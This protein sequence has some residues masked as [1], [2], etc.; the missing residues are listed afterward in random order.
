MSDNLR[1]LTTEEQ[2][3]RLYLARRRGGMWAACGRVIG[4]D[5]T[6][7]VEHFRIGPEGS[8]GVIVWAAV[9]AE[10]VSP[11]FL[12]DTREREPERCAGCGRGMYYRVPNTRRRRA[13]CSRYC[14][15]RAVV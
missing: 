15:G 5:E 7:Y 11:S 9:G 12:D 3:E 4:G 1:R 10:C 6:V 14:A 2:R 8:L 13:L